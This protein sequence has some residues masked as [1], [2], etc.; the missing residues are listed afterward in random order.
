MRAILYNKLLTSS[1]NLLCGKNIKM[2]NKT[3]AEIA[4]QEIERMI[5]FGELDI[6]LLYS[7]NKLAN[8]LNLGRTPVREALQ[9]LEQM[10]L[11]TIHP[12]KGIEFHTI[13]PEQQIQLLEI[14]RRIEPICL[15]FAIM[16][17]TIEQ[18]NRMIKLGYE[19]V[20]NSREKNQTQIL[21][22]LQEVHA[23]LCEATQNPYFHHALGEIQ[24]SSRRFWFDN[25]IDG[26]ELVAAII[27]Q[28]ILNSVVLGNLNSALKFSSDLMDH[29]AQ[30]AFIKMKS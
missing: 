28:N 20:K 1:K 18:K 2:Q 14:R 8:L 23:L 10:N 19:I 30:D 25:K 22:C 11:L 9:S 6:H 17:G 7:E 13:S 12:K 4:S 3:Q 26:D 29:L 5:V 24:F 27:H 21:Y 15:E 16:R